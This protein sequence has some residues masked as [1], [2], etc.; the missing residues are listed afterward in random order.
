[1]AFDSNASNLV[2]GDTNGHEDIF[3]RDRKTGKTTRVSLSSSG[4]QGDGDS[5]GP[6]ISADGRFVAFTSAAA[7]LVP[8]DANVK[9][10]AFVHDRKTGK[11]RLVSVN[12]S[13][14]QGTG[15]SFP[16]SI[17]ANGRWV[18]FTSDAG[19]LVANDNNGVLDV[20]VHDRKSGKTKRV[21]V[22]SAGVEGTS[23]SYDSSISTDGR[24]VA[25]KSDATNMVAHDTN[26]AGDV[27]I[28]DRKNGK[29][30]RVSVNSLGE[31]GN[32]DSYGASISADGRF[33]AFGSNAT[34]L[35]AHDTNLAG[36]IFV[37]DRKSGKTRRVSVSSAGVEGNDLSGESM[38]SAGGRFVAFQSDATNLVGHDQNIEPDVFVRDL[39]TGKTKCISVNSAGVEGNGESELPSVSADGRF[40]AFGSLATNLAGIDTNVVEDV[41]LRGP[42]R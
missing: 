21:S 38:I 14:V 22:S 6:S 2:G 30:K 31:P 17:S 7:N 16:D 8:G 29:T 11:T 41:F 10:D 18:A 34:N 3:V 13:G 40:V 19:N 36:D 4:A 9:N 27:F 25:F 32:G 28:H 12:S 39:Q 15:N 37:R 24:F 20:F 5:Y 26:L 35:V 23:D 1:V 33:V 42:L